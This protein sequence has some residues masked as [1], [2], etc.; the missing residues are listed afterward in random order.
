MK[1][2]FKNEIIH[3][4]AKLNLDLVIGDFDA[5]KSL[6]KIKS[7]VISINY[8][9]TLKVSGILSSDDR[10][11]NVKINPIEQTCKDNSKNT[12]LRAVEAWCSLRNVGCKIEIHHDDNVPC[13]KGLG[14]ASSNAGEILLLLEKY[15]CNSGYNLLDN[16]QL[17]ALALSIGSDVPYF[18]TGAHNALVSGC[19][20]IVKPVREDF[21][22]KFILH[23]PDFNLCTQNGF[24]K[25]YKG[26]KKIF[27][28]F[29][30]IE[31]N[32]RYYR[33]L[34]D[35]SGK[36]EWKLTGSGSAFFIESKSTELLEKCQKIE[37]SKS[38]LVSQ[39]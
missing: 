35:K 27:S 24:K 37:N 13:Q 4:Y 20:E 28:H 33:F 11:I 21:K 7:H 8:F 39:I 25:L 17:N 26:G 16:T 36:I 34:C 3:S 18:V 6:H 14:I 38:L 31:E 32:Q 5:I 15:A 2:S 29:I 10:S 12:M 19:G 23:I 1:I 9:E 22:R 30:E